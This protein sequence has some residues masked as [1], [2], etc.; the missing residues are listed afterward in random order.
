VEGIVFHLM[1]QTILSRGQE[2]AINRKFDRNEY[3]LREHARLNALERA[4]E[5]TQGE[6]APRASMLTLIR[7]FVPF[8]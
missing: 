6:K 7:S 8:L 4:S 1:F 5:R 2:L 3:W